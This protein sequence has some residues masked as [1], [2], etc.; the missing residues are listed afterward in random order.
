M[1]F[2][3]TKWLWRDRP[4]IFENFLGTH[5]KLPEFFLITGKSENIDEIFKTDK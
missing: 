2:V 3:S 1:V 4:L 5:R